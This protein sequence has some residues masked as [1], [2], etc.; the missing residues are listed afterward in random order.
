MSGVFTTE[1]HTL[2]NEPGSDMFETDQ[3]DARHSKIILQL[4]LKARRHLALHHLRVN[5][6]VGENS[7]ANYSLNN[8]QSHIT[9]GVKEGDSSSRLRLSRSNLPHDSRTDHPIF[10]VGS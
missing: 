6:E 5:T 9:S 1:T 2:R 3:T 7:P 4:W 10:A 8:G